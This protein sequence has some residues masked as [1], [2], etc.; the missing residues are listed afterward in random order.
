MHPSKQGLTTCPKLLFAIP[1]DEEGEGKRGPA[2]VYPPQGW[3]GHRLQVS[4]HQPEPQ[5]A[6]QGALSAANPTQTLP[7]GTHSKNILS[8]ETPRES[9][10]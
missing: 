10:S 8:T 7:L 3:H 5:E 2:K 1:L 9:L 4:F 6:L